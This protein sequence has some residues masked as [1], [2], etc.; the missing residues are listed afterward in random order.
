[1]LRLG[2]IVTICALALGQPAQLK[3]NRPTEIVIIRDGRSKLQGF[4]APRNDPYE[5]SVCCPFKMPAPDPGNVRDEDGLIV[6]GFGY[7]SWKQDGAIHV[8]VLALVPRPGAPNR[9]LWTTP[10]DLRPRDFVTFKLSMGQTHLVAEMKRLGLEPIRVSL[11][12][13]MP[14]K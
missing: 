11:E 9:F 7:Y 14:Q 13:E 1:M 2:I 3:P 4:F 6:S 10:G 8:R 5:A 12:R